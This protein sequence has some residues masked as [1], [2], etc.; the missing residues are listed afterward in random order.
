MWPEKIYIYIAGEKYLLKDE[1]LGWFVCVH[2]LKLFLK[3][4][5]TVNINV[6]MSRFYFKEMKSNF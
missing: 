6:N 4:I 1:I 2:S 3:N 5:L